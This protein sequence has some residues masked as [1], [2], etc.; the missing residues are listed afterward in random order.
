MLRCRLYREGSSTD[1]LA[2]IICFALLS[3]FLIVRPRPSLAANGHAQMLQRD[4]EL[5]PKLDAVK[6]ELD[7]QV[8]L[9]RAAPPSYKAASP[10]EVT[11][12]FYDWYLHAG[13]PIP[14]R[15]NMATFRKFVTQGFLKRATAPDVDAILFI[16]AQDTDATWADNF[17]VSKATI[18]GQ[19]ATL[20]VA[21][22]GREMKSNLRVTLRRM[23]GVWKIDGVKGSAV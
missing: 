12:Q 17:N 20:Q 10:E 19:R 7:L 8:F 4:P 1:L 18:Q 21:L 14:K 11:R 23:G 2:F 16:D 5:L 9:A 15:S 22:N 3:T 6:A 13:L